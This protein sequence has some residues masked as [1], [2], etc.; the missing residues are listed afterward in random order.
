M[1][2]PLIHTAVNKKIPIQ[3]PSCSGQ[4]QVRS[5]ECPACHTRVEGLFSLPLLTS[6]SEEDQLFIIEFVKS[7]GSLKEM[8]K[9]LK[10]SYP[11]VRNKLD[12]LIADIR[13]LQREKNHELD[14]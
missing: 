4:L 11:S 8:S 5:L 14:K 7:S 10:L 2:K 13:K 6:L 3:C 9:H 12:D 1:K